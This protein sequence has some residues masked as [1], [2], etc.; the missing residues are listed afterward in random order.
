MSIFAALFALGMADS[1]VA[2]GDGRGQADCAACGGQLNDQQTGHCCRTCEKPVHSWTFCDKVWQ[3]E[4]GAYF[5][6]KDCLIKYNGDVEIRSKYVSTD[7]LSVKHRPDDDSENELPAP[8][9]ETD[10]PRRDADDRATY[11]R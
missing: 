10:G 1:G 4:Y 6:S 11:R 9:N 8:Q 7:K 5:C 3:P 2:D